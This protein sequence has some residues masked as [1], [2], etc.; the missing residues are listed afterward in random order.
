MGRSLVVMLSL[1]LVF[2]LGLS[3]QLQ[4][5]PDYDL[6]PVLYSASK[7]DNTITR[8]QAAMDAQTF[9]LSGSSSAEVLRSLLDELGISVS[10]Q[11][12]VFSRQVCSGK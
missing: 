11:V 9:N 4:A 6:A 5:S 7:D 10:S 3:G 1:Q 8:I 12:L 2:Q